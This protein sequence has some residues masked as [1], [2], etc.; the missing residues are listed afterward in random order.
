MTGSAI[1]PAARAAELH[2]ILDRAGRAYYERDAPEMADAEYDRLFREL[3]ALEAADSSLRTPDSPTQRVGGAVAAGLVKHEH[4]RRMLSLDNAFGADALQKWEERNAKLVPSVRESGYTTEIK[5]DGA[6]I[7]LTYRHGR[8]VIGAT[9]GNGQIGEDVT[10]NLK[11]IADVP[12]VL[13]GAGFPSL[14]EVRGEVYLPIASLEAVN[15]ERAAAGEPP[16]ANP[17]N[18]A[19]GALRQLDPGVTRRR[20]LRFFAFHVE[21]IDGTLAAATQAQLIADL[22]AWGFPTA[23]QHRRFASLTEVQA[24]MPEYEAMLR[25]LPFLADGVVVK[26][27]RRA[28]HAE[29]GIVGDRDPRWAIARKFA[30]EV[31][32]TRLKAIHLGVGRTGALNPYAELEPVELGGV[33]VSSAT[34][35]NEDQ[36]AQKDVRIGDW[37]E[38]V[39][40]GEVIPQILGPL[41]ERRTGDEAVFTMPDQCPVCGTPVE[42]PPDEV[43]RY[44]PNGACPGR[45]LEGLIHFAARSAM[46]IRG[47]GT[48]R[49]RQLRDAGLVTD[50]SDLYR[51]TVDD[52]LRLEGFA[53]VSAKALIDAIAMSKAQPLSL[54]L[55]GIGIRHVGETVAK[56]LARRFGSMD[57][58]LAATPEQLN[59]IAGV[60]P[61]IAE[62][63][64]QWSA[65]PANRALVGRFAASGLPMV[66]AD[67]VSGDGPLQG[68]TFVITGTLPTLSRQDTTTLIE[69]AGGKVSGSV[70]KKTTAVVAGADAGSKLDKARALGVPVIEED[71]LLRRCAAEG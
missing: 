11:T 1:G 42:R 12:L 6:A 64:A 17:R 18:A 34:L 8:L 48:E 27:D 19:A 9:R 71:E 3:Q 52:L 37:V 45:V 30:P 33:V 7:S 51:L 22:E 69:R 53:E 10:A 14:M 40:A 59:D 58:L 29:L 41:R 31:A 43:M 21:P 4:R 56:L 35:H 20:R 55:F 26:V 60:G 70:S 28:L 66:E 54:V 13:R 38:V 39:R 49:V 61:T 68:Q 24:A 23:P 65:E 25:S 16:L 36:I 63:V 62:A 46:D 2:R 15:R 50:A 5:I 32:V 67:A 57:G 47:L 44:C